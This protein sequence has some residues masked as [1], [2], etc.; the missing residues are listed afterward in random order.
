MY[1]AHTD[2]NE[3]ETNFVA[4]DLSNNNG[5]LTN[6]CTSN[7]T[8][9]MNYVHSQK[10]KFMDNLSTR[11]R[12]NVEIDG[13]SVFSMVRNNIPVENYNIRLQLLLKNVALLTKEQLEAYNTAVDYISGKNEN[14]MRMFVSGE[15]G[16]DKSFLISLI[17]DFTSIIHG[18]QN[19]TYGA[20]VA[21]AP[22]A[23]RQMSSED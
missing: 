22:T 20:A 17:M 11:N 2:R 7:K 13:D 4:T 18:K 1:N 16:T 8:Y 14:Q 23:R 5:V 21:V 10:K 9:L 12:F 3:S 19:G 15:G 6:M